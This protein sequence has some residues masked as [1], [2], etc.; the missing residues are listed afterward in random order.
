MFGLADEFVLLGAAQ[1]IEEHIPAAHA[2]LKRRVFFGIL[3]RRPQRGR[4][5]HIKLY[6]QP[7][8]LEI[9]LYQPHKRPE[10][11]RPA[12]RRGVEDAVQH[13]AVRELRLIKPPR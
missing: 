5:E 7:A 11:L 13:R 3:L 2:H 6:S 4:V 1:M 12:H 8:Q 9:C 10:S